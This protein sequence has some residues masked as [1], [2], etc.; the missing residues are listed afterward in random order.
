M[1][2][3]RKTAE[4]ELAALR[5]RQEEVEQLE[6][7]RN[8]LLASWSAAVP[9][10]PDRLTPEGRNEIYRTLRLE[11]RPREEGYEVTGPF[12]TSEPLSS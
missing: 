9:G 5:H 11:M 4:R 7:D 1:D 3:S 2:E 6:R 12:C 8:T 10:D